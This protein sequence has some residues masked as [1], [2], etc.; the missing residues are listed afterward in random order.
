MVELYHILK[1]MGLIKLL[2]GWKHLPGSADR[3]AARI[4]KGE[5]P[6]FVLSEENGIPMDQQSRALR[7]MKSGYGSS[8]DEVYHGS[9]SDIDSFRP[10]THFG[11]KRAANEAIGGGPESRHLASEHRGAL[12]PVSLS[13][14]KH[15]DRTIDILN[16][17]ETPPLSKF[18]REL[19]PSIRRKNIDT[20]KY[21]NEAE[22]AGSISFINTKPNVRG[23]YAAHNPNWIKLRDLLATGALVTLPKA[24]SR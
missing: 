21:T 1:S 9:F 22:D 24:K 23:R 5:S 12:Y 13:E 2:R 17:L 15:A 3:A 4:K 8:K 7:A 18:I 6:Y 14:S 11:T 16:D 19:D 20:L 10:G